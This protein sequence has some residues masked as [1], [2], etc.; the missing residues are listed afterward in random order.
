MT[1][2]AGLSPRP[3]PLLACTISRD[4]GRFDQLV[5]EMESELGDQW[6][7]LSLDRAAAFIST[8]TALRFVVF[9]LDGEDEG[10]PAVADAIAAARNVGL[11]V[12][13]VINGIG[14]IGLQQIL[15]FCPDDVLAYPLSH[16]ALREAATQGRKDSP[17]GL[18]PSDDIAPSARRPMRD[19]VV[20]PVV[21]VAGGVG[22][23]T[24]AVG[25]A[26]ELGHR[27]RTCLIDL[28]PCSG[29]VGAAL[30]LHNSQPSGFPQGLQQ[31]RGRF[32]VLIA[33]TSA[34]RDV[35]RLIA[36]ARADF[37]LVLLDLPTGDTETAQAVI[38]HA[39][40]ALAVMEPD[41][42]CLRSAAQLV[43][44]LDPEARPKLRHI[45][46]RAPGVVDFAGRARMKRLAGSLTVAANL[47]DGGKAVGLAA[48]RGAPLAETAP[49]NGFRRSLATL[50]ES[51][52]L[53][54]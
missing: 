12:I 41:A 5:M 32:H 46:N 49:R 16:G 36:Q 14:P 44:D 26:W 29:A 52:P 25:I 48:E 17:T 11:R 28:D 13:L 33:A 15:R 27:H 54:R 20:I 39:D 23:T 42:R 37:D 7:D 34:R 50:A 51:L 43:R 45:V 31:W 8:A 1:S 9:A 40:L 19:G 47:P 22:A 4:L 6:G 35:A 21:G 53:R 38:A 3:A 18:G 30:N 10:N 2:F 24:L